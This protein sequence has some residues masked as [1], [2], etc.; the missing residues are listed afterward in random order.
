MS[1]KSV[2]RKNEEGDFEEISIEQLDINDVIRVKAGQK[3]PV[4]GQIEFGMGAI[5]ESFLTG[6]S[7]PQDKTNKKKKSMLVQ[8]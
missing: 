4:D 7:I 5:D 6:E 8:F 3:I 2:E 1:V